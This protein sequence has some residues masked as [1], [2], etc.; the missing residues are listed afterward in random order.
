MLSPV[1]LHSVNILLKTY[2][3]IGALLGTEGT[4]VWKNH[5]PHGTYIL[6]RD[7]ENKQINK[8]NM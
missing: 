4:A 7:T 6:V 8:F 3:M 1:E 2:N 5:C